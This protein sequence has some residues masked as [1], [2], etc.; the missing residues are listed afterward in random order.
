MM[1]SQM[2][3]V[4]P[5]FAFESLMTLPVAGIDEAGC[6]PW[7]G[8]LVSAAV[9]FRELPKT[10]DTYL[11]AIHDSKLLKEDMRV[12]LYDQLMNDSNVD[13]GIGIV[14]SDELDSIFLKHALPLSYKRAIANLEISPQSLLIDGIR[15]PKIDIETRMITKGD[16]LSVSIAAASIIAK[17]TRDDMMKQLHQEYPQYGWGTNKGY[18]TKKHQEAIQNYGVCEHHRKSYAPIKAFISQ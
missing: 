2:D 12:K 9:V 3:K 8:P 10:M 6:G 11:N 1:L 17:V 18:G 14:N 16:R 15:N 5:S 7:A 13:I 4:S